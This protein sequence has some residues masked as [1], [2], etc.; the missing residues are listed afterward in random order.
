VWS[1][2]RGAV[3][4]S[5]LCLGA[6][7]SQGGDSTAVLVGAGDI[8]SCDGTRPGKSAEATA[9]LLDRI[10]GAVFTA[11]DN[12]YQNGSAA[13]FMRCYEPTWGRHK[14]RTHPV[15]GNHEYVMP[16]AAGYFGYFGAAAGDSGKGYYSYSLGSWHIVALNSNIDMRPGSPQLRWLRADLAAHPTRCALAYWHHPRFSSGT[17][18]GSAKETLPLWQALY[19][20]GV[21]VVIAG[22]EH[23]YERFAP[24]DP[25]GVADPARGIREFVVGT[26]GDSH[27]PLG[28]PIANSE[29]AN[30]ATFGVLR[31]TLEPAGY[32]W[33]FIPVPGKTFT[34][35]G[36]GSC[37]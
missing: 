7:I 19:E 31:L 8:A 21:D 20:A 36:S 6:G 24:Q 9:K 4:L 16:G 2:R 15:A 29:V 30:S 37:H 35:A 22:H 26:G 11:G 10:A 1:V 13:E 33:E 17:T 18:H 3:C 27:F 34:D 25:L 32:H 28:P 23:N 14:R 5:A 12:A